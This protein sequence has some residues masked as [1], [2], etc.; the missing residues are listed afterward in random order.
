MIVIKKVQEIDLPQLGAL[1]EQLTGQLSNHDKMLTVY[2]KMAETPDYTLIG[3]YQNDELIG[4]VMGVTCYELVGDC[5]PFMVVEN[6]IVSDLHRGLGVGKLLM[7][8]IE[9]IA[10]EQSCTVLMFVS[11]AYRKEA[12]RFYESIGYAGDVVRGF[13]KFLIPSS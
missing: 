12:H 4:S 3:A 5:E 6:V 2:H 11:S 9:D 1:Y 13:K 8:A 10:R 7:A